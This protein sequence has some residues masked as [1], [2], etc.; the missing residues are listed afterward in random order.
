MT[1]L[2]QEPQKKQPAA[3]DTVEMS[4][5]RR[6]PTEPT[7]IRADIN[8][9]NLTQFINNEDIEQTL[10][11]ILPANNKSSPKKHAISP[12]NPSPP[13]TSTKK[14]FCVPNTIVCTPDRQFDITIDEYET[15]TPNNIDDEE[16][17]TGTVD[18]EYLHRT[19]NNNYSS[20]TVA[21]APGRLKDDSSYVGLSDSSRTNIRNQRTTLD[22]NQ[23]SSE[24]NEPTTTPSPN[25][26]TPPVRPNS[27]R[28]NNTHT[29]GINNHGITNVLPDN[30]QYA[31]TTTFYS[32]RNESNNDPILQAFLREFSSHNTYPYHRKC[33]DLFVFYFISPTTFIST[34][35]VVTTGS[36][37]F[38]A[39]LVPWQLVED[40]RSVYDGQLILD[41]DR[42]AILPA[43]ATMGLNLI[44]IQPPVI[45]T[46]INTMM[47]TV[48]GNLFEALGMRSIPTLHDFLTTN[49]HGR[50]APASRP[51]N[52][53]FSAIPC[54]DNQVAAEKNLNNQTE[55]VIIH[56][57]QQLNPNYWYTQMG[58]AEK[59]DGSGTVTYLELASFIPTFCI[60]ETQ[61]EQHNTA[62]NWFEQHSCG[63]KN[64]FFKLVLYDAYA[65]TFLHF[66]NSTMVRMARIHGFRPL[67]MLKNCILQR[68][69][70]FGKNGY[71]FASCNKKKGPKSTLILLGFWR[72][73][74]PTSAEVEL[75]GLQAN[76]SYLTH[77]TR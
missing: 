3:D 9:T 73:P 60:H 56:G 35:D 33:L 43:Q 39:P 55:F 53:I 67:F 42:Q 48:F 11:P 54:V 77:S 22:D 19:T 64:E 68:D 59:I 66:M 71:K 1:E 12:N 27:N 51:H 10:Q 29:R 16:E 65:Y 70:R 24:N 58:H 44:G 61:N 17:S 57:R 21:R 31:L 8:D 46:N 47:S 20:T 15:L 34:G 30:G 13:N 37:G 7:D 41:G 38:S 52:L 6:E 26:T 75:I 14:R 25:T 40:Y 5:S 63:L 32:K 50:L 72:L 69:N 45:R 49:D 2:P 4:A 28:N 62:L 74:H 18:I 36:D 76:N 23:H